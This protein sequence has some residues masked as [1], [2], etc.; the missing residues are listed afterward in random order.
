MRKKTFKVSFLGEGGVGKTTLLKHMSEGR[1]V[2]QVM[3]IGVNFEKVER[4]VLVDREWIGI[5]LMFW[6]LGG[7]EHFRKTHPERYVA[8]SDAA[9][10][11]FDVSRRS[12]LLHL[13]WWIGMLE[14]ACGDGILGR[15]MLVGLKSDLVP[16]GLT[17]RY[18]E[19]I[20]G[21]LADRGI[22]GRCWSTSSLSGL[23]TE[24]AL[25]AIVEFL[26][27][28]DGGLPVRHMTYATA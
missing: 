19:M 26:L 8:G 11:G 7:Q 27:S 28:R 24:E 23:G 9:V 25:R 2:E 10:L 15:S 3:T 17:G 4:E 21:F 5:T 20:R 22:P 16:R 6:D 14:R 1:F 13:D 12:T 18:G